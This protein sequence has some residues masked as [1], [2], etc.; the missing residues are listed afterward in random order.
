M[1]QK[2]AI[3]S[4]MLGRNRWF[5]KAELKYVPLLGWGIWS[6]G[7][8]MVSRKWLQDQKELDRVFNGIVVRKWPTCKFH[9]PHGFSLQLY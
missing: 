3:K 1:I 8:P 5:A 7:M 6:M 2:L 4:R 9:L